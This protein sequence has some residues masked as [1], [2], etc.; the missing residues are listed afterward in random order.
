M[1]RIRSSRT[2]RFAH[3]APWFLAAV[4]ATFVLSDRKTEASGVCYDPT[5]LHV[6]MDGSVILPGDLLVQG[7][8]IVM[9]GGDLV[10]P[11]PGVDTL[12]NGI[13]WEALAGPSGGPY[14]P[15]AYFMGMKATEAQGNW[16][17]RDS[18]FCLSWNFDRC[19]GAKL[20]GHEAGMKWTWESKFQAAYMSEPLLEH[21]VAVFHEDGT[22]HRYRTEHAFL[23]SDRVSYN[24]VPDVAQGS[25]F[26]INRNGNIKVGPQRGQP[27]RDLDLDEMRFDG[28]DLCWKDLAGERVLAACD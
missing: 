15:T 16:M 4:A 26:Q 14:E 11:E 2:A 25:T 21:N 13:V 6:E 3:A 9:E 28:V 8:H 27:A 10:F 12:P 19:G 24:F 17:W 7:G 22:N 18:V 20:V 1:A 23:G 5:A